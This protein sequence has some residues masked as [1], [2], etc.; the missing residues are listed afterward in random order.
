MISEYQMVT[1]AEDAEEKMRE[2]PMLSRI[3]NMGA[4]ASHPYF[5]VFFAYFEVSFLNSIL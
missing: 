4:I 1:T 5:S 3:I 2:R